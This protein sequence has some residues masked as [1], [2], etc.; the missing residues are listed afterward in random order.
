LTIPFF[1]G[2]RTAI[3]QSRI[4]N[5]YLG[6]V[7]SLSYSV[8]LFATPLGLL[9][10]GGFSEIAGVQNCFFICRVLAICLALAMLVTPS[11][12]DSND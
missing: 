11:I 8:S 5:E 9:L 6:R 1:Y 10:G 2:L 4:P 12:R 3:F 7:L